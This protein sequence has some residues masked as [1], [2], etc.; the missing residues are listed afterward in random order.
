MSNVPPYKS[1]VMEPPRFLIG[2]ALLFVPGLYVV[3]LG[4]LLAVLGI[5]GGL[6][7]L[8]VLGVREV[9]SGKLIILAVLLGVGVV[10]GVISVIKGIICSLWPRI[11]F[12]PAIAIDFRRERDLG[13]ILAPLCSTVDTRMP[14]AVILHAEPTFFVMQGKLNTFSG[15]VQ[16]RVLAIGLPLLAGLTKNEFRAVLAHELAHFSGSDTLYS[17]TVLPVYE[18]ASTTW[19]EMTRHMAAA[20]SLSESIPMIL[21]RTA[22]YL[23]LSAFH[24]ID[25]HISRKRELRADAIAVATCG[26][27]SFRKGLMKTVGIG[28]AFHDDRALE[29]ARR[30]HAAHPPNYHIGFRA[31][32]PQLYPLAKEYCSRAMA[33]AENLRD[34]HPSL[35]RRLDLA[36]SVPERYSD[37]DP[38]ITL[39]ADLPAY[40]KQLGEAYTAMLAAVGIT[41]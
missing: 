3:L 20:D 15:M 13:Y 36:A 6:I 31:A 16:G 24:Y 9:H 23:Y 19:E 25:M 28:G 27:E 10:V 8:C 5:G 37:N 18:G 21:P 40:E 12:E 33:E 34:S 26:T 14:N 2:L 29:A 4:S 32:L 1:N 7:Y 39:L 30:A 38:A 17:S 22:L 11:Q 41:R 35:K